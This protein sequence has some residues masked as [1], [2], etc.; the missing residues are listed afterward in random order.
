MTPDMQRECTGIISKKT[1]L[2]KKTD[3]YIHTKMSEVFLTYCIS[4]KG[5]GVGL[6]S[7]VAIM[8]CHSDDGAFKR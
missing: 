1:E 2:Y 8:R 7:C 4:C 3:Q 6:H 5:K